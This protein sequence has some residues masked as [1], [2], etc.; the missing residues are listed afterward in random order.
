M[1]CF[2]IQ[3]RKCEKHWN[4]FIINTLNQASCENRETSVTPE[5]HIFSF[6]NTDE[7]ISVPRNNELEDAVGCSENFMLYILVFFMQ[8]K[9]VENQQGL[10]AAGV[11]AEMREGSAEADF[12][13]SLCDFREA[14][15]KALYCPCVWSREGLA[16]LKPCESCTNNAIL[17]LPST[18]YFASEIRLE[19]I[20]HLQQVTH[21]L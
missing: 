9:I 21:I 7:F 15:L 20:R 16:A 18:A 2:Y 11:C 3:N 10:Q 17:C 19:S 1:V 12:M 4:D 6:Y 14:F 5:L 8:P 13:S